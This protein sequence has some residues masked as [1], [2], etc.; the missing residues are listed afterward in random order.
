ME[1]FSRDVKYMGDPGEQVLYSFAGAESLASWRVW[2]DAELGGKSSASL[3]PSPASPEAALFSGVYS[4]DIAET[5]S[6]RLKKSGFAGM[7]SLVTGD[8]TNLQGFQSLIYRVRG[9]GRTY[10]ANLRTDNWIL[11][12]QSDDAWQAF[13]ITRSDGEWHNIEVPL[14]EF[15]LTHKGRVIPGEHEMHPGRVISMGIALAGGEAIQQPGPF[16]LEIEWIKGTSAAGGDDDSRPYQPSW[17]NVPPP[18]V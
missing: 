12:T 14:Q 15:M 4:T 17:A 1:K 11:G 18:K 9:D 8:Y 16:S 13:L 5:A 7:S 10:I 3:V 6:E 2:S